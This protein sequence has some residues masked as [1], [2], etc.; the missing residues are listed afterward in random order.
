[1]PPEVCGEHPLA[2]PL[3]LGFAHAGETG[4]RK[5]RRVEL[6]DERAHIFRVPVMVGV[7]V[8]EFGRAERLGQRFEALR[9]AEPGEP[10]AQMPHP[11]AEL[12]GQALPHQRVRAVGADDDIGA[13][14]LLDPLDSA[15]V[16]G[17]D[18][19]RAR[20]LL[21]HGKQLE[22]AHRRKADAVDRDPFAAMHDG[23]VLPDLEMRRDGV[24][25]V[26]VVF[27]QELQRAIGEHHAEAEGRIRAVLLDE[28]DLRLGKAPLQQIG[29]IEPGRAGAE[30]GHAHGL[31]NQISEVGGQAGL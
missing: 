2:D 8:T 15:A 18:A 25:G 7:A 5:A 26:G 12:A 23:D 29:E 21:Q 3:R 27:F 10:I 9:R 6:D 28:A 1:M 13:V 19:D 14:E 11:G 22:P 4:A 30:N 31:R 20:P 17:L 16:F 24:V